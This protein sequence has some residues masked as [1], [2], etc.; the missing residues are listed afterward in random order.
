MSLWNLK[1]LIGENKMAK[2]A[3]YTSAMVATATEMYA[4]LGNDGMDAIATALVKSVRS[5][6]AKLVREGVYVA[7]TKEKAAPRDMG[8]T[9]GELLES[10]VGMGY[11]V[12]GLEGATKPAILRLIELMEGVVTAPESEVESEVEPE[13]AFEPDF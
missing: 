2:S 10:L 4:E 9:K 12:D 11:D 7:D 6:R 13:K 5:V 8:P 1:Q 3:N